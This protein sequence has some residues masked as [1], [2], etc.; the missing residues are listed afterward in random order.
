ME[1]KWEQK[2][3][4][5][6][7]GEVQRTYSGHARYRGRRFAAELRLLAAER[8]VARQKGFN[9]QR[10]RQMAAPATARWAVFPVTDTGGSTS[11]SDRNRVRLHVYYY[12]YYFL[13]ED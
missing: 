1:R 3:S 7:E 5:L 6:P 12:Y 11:L 13:A 8:S 9:P 10:G 4:N 2:P